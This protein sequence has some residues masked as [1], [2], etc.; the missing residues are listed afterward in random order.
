MLRG[1]FSN[2]TEEFESCLEILR[3][4]LETCEKLDPPGYELSADVLVMMMLADFHPATG[5][6]ESL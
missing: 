1:S 5:S 4:R 6:L 2:E 3:E